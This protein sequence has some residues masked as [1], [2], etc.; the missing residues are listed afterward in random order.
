M[1]C[2]TFGSEVIFMMNLSV[3]P[4]IVLHPTKH[5]VQLFE[6]LKGKYAYVNGQTIYTSIRSANI[7]YKQLFVYL[8]KNTL[9]SC[10]YQTVV[11]NWEVFKASMLVSWKTKTGKN[12]QEITQSSFASWASTL[13]LTIEKNILP[14]A[15]QLQYSPGLI[16][17]ERYIDWITAVGF[18]PIAKCKPNPKHMAHLDLQLKLLLS[19]S[20]EHDTILQEMLLNMATDLKKTLEKLTSLYIPDYSE[21][22]V[23]KD[24]TS[25]GLYGRYNGKTIHVEV[26]YTPIVNGGYCVFDS[27]VQR[28]FPTVMQ[29]FRTREHAKLC[30]LLNTPPIK[31]ILGPSSS[32]GYKDLLKHIENSSQKSDPKKD[33]FNLLLNLAE[34]KTVSGV[35]DVV[36]DFISDVS[37]NLIDKN[38]LFG[39]QGES[40]ASGLRKQVSNSVFKCLTK[41]INEQFDTIGDLKKEREMYVSKL[42]ALE[43]QLLKLSRNDESVPGPSV[44][45]LTADTLSSLQEVKDL[46]H[47]MVTNDIKEGQAV[48]NSFFSQ[49][50]PPFRELNKDLGSLWESEFMHTFKLIPEVDAQGKL[51]CVKYTQETISMLLGP[52]TYTI[53]NLYNINLLTGFM[54]VQSLQ[55]LADDIYDKSRLSVYI[56][57]IEEK[58]SD[59]TAG[60]GQSQHN[61]N[62]YS[63]NIGKDDASNYS[64]ND[65]RTQHQW[66]SNCCSKFSTAG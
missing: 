42:E 58:F 23:Y 2:L 41:Q 13:K 37:S 48:L 27:C 40:A 62:G 24:G 9:N 36:E 63:Q 16:S 31:A 22:T 14:L 50:V 35:S 30:Q 10:T 51:I 8:Y 26:I 12:I 61:H 21:V 46:K 56:R 43:T 4:D 33:M 65:A 64:K 28:I 66:K 55:E 6:I 29:C 57:D 47:N 1:I 34:N 25:G 49:Y 11:S 19:E 54:S 38:K 32:H 59:Y 15:V 45:F 5:S 39:N 7:F 3:N 18:V 53:A 20:A 60:L 52:F 17:Y 44:N